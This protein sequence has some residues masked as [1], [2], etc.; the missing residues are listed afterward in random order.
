[1]AFIFVSVYVALY[2]RG[3]QV[4]I[5]AGS[6]RLTTN[7]CE[8]QLIQWPPTWKKAVATAVGTQGVHSIGKSAAGSM[9]RRSLKGDRAPGGH[10]K[11]LDIPG[12][13]WDLY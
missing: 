3:R 7:L 13:P 8:R 10:S 4:Y 1:M 11:S 12:H 9:G 6:R 5:V 2:M